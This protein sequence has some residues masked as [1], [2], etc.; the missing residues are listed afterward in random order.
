MVTKKELLASPK[1]HWDE[2]SQLYDEVLMVQGRTKHSSGWMHII[3]IG[4]ISDEDRFEI[5]CENADDIEWELDSIIRFGDK[6][7]YTMSQVR[8]DCF[9]PQGIFR[10][11]S[12]AGKFRVGPALSSVKVEFIK[13]E[14]Y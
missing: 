6:Q 3:L 14:K 11:H 1:R 2:S 9:Y 7:Q 5:C 13:T 10:F 12:R 8:M 4:Y